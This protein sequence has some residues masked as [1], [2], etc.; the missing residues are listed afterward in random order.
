MMSVEGFG[1]VGSPSSSRRMITSVTTAIVVEASL[2]TLSTRP[3]SSD[4]WLAAT[5]DPTD[6]RSAPNVGAVAASSCEPSASNGNAIGPGIPHLHE[7]H[8]PGGPLFLA[9][10][11]ARI[12]TATRGAVQPPKNA[13]D[14]AALER[15]RQH[16][17]ADP[18]R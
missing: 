9:H 7:P 3:S 1:V 12:L 15:P 11:S 2:L 17:I 6:L 5:A 4:D 8:N 16:S 13:P 14:T 18:P 10:L